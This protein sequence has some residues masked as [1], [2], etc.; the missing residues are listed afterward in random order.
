MR[1]A[2]II[3]D[4]ESYSPGEIVRGDVLI[5]CDKPFT[6]DRVS[7]TLV[8]TESATVIVG[9]GKNSRRCTNSRNLVELS[10]DLMGPGRIESGETC[11][12]FELKIP[13]DCPGLFSES[14]CSVEHWLR[15]RLVIPRAIDSE[16]ALRLAVPWELP[17][18]SSS[19]ISMPIL[20][21][22]AEVMT[23]HL[24]SDVIA[25]S[26]T[27]TVRFMLL[28]EMKMRGVRFELRHILVL[29]ACGHTDSFHEVKSVARLPRDEIHYQSWQE[30][31]LQ[32]PGNLAPVLDLDMIKS[33][34][35]LAAIIDIPLAFD[36][37][38]LLPLRLG[39]GRS[40]SDNRD[41]F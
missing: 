23:V 11:L 35:Q 13:P 15:A 18:L 27:L 12:P 40:S 16:A 24:E 21:D 3:V 37:K 28:R 9:N 8:C 33:S 25:P 29:R 32:V 41:W 20:E 17:H 38:L 19:E 4:K 1:R 14:R 10:Q 31:T 36:K 39:S 7:I 34:Y 2:K 30:V 26:S 22:G 5:E 6:V